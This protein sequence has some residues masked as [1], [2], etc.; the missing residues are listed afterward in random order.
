LLRAQLG[1]LAGITGLKHIET[2]QNS[3]P[4]LPYEKSARNE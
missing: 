2:Q 1:F 4:N 3:K